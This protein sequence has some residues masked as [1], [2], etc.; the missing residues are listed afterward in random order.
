[1]TDPFRNYNPPPTPEQLKA[2]ACLTAADVHA[3]SRTA[4]HALGCGDGAKPAPPVAVDESRH[5]GGPETHTSELLAQAR[6]ADRALPLKKVP[7]EGNA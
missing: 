5:Y 1:M 3:L 2:T 7:G 6:A 4:S